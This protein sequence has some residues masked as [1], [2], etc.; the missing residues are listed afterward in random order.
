[1]SGKK[2]CEVAAVLSQGESARRV[3]NGVYES[4]LKQVIST[5]LNGAKAMVKLRERVTAI[6]FDV[7]E[8][9]SRIF[10]TKVDIIAQS[11]MQISKEIRCA[12]DASNAAKKGQTEVDAIREE[13]KS[14]DEK[15]R[16]IRTAIS[17][18]SHYC[19]KEFQ[20]ARDVLK[21]Y[22]IQRLRL[23]KS[24]QQTSVA[25]AGQKKTLNNL[26]AKFSQL[27][28]LR[29]QLD[30]MNLVAKNREQADGMRHQ[31]NDLLKTIVEEQANKFMK[32]E[33]KA[34]KSEVLVLL[35]EN[36]A[37]VLHQFAPIYGKENTFVKQLEEKV[38]LWTQQKQ[39]AEDSI[40][41]IKNLM[42]ISLYEP[43]D[44]TI[45][46]EQGEKTYLLDYL[47]VYGNDD[48]RKKYQELFRKVQSK[49]SQE[50]FLSVSKLMQKAETDLEKLRDQG[51]E[52]QES[53]LK[54]V[55]LAVA[56]QD[57]MGELHYDVKSEL[58]TDNPNDGFRLSCSVGDEIIDF[59]K[60][61]ISDDGNIIIDVDHHESRTGTC[62]AE[63]KAIT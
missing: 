54:K 45:H 17:S 51:I 10:G 62:G 58:I 28:H 36:D 20:Q 44:Y 42:E 7:D 16:Q 9:A 49:M 26:R 35:G 50:D 59:E 6:H 37:S 21:Q 5:I 2:S 56:I 30:Q 15:A 40:Q 25:A 31:L 61:S 38:A 53:M 1:M 3:A 60:I 11:M 14:I 8:A 19:D 29:K 43:I 12:R 32:A 52:L 39:N 55:E 22:E 27:Q 47:A 24:L 4:Q 63:W 48:Q 33:Y 57:V 41:R 23:Q 18:K 13:M 34:L 46:G